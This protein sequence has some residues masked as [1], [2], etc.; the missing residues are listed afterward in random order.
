MNKRWILVTTTLLMIVTA[1][2]I[3]VSPV[4]AQSATRTLPDSVAPGETFEVRIE[5]TD[6]GMAGQVIETL[7]DGFSYVNSSLSPSQVTQEDQTVTFTLLGETSFTYNVTA[8]STPGTYTFSGI[9]KDFEKNEY[10]IGGDKEIKVIG[11][12]PTATRTLPT[13][14][15]PGETFEVRIEA[16]DYGMAGQ[17]IETLPDGFSYV[18]SSLSPSQVTQE[19]QTVTFT[20]LGETSFTYNVT[21][22]STPGTYTFSGILKDFEKNEYDIGGDSSIRVEVP[23][24]PTPTPTYRHA[25]GGVTVDSDGDGYSDSYEIRMGTDPHD[26]KSYPGAPTPKVTPTPSPSPSP[27]PTP[28]PILT[29]TPPLPGTPTPTPTLTPTPSP[30]PSP[31]PPGFEAIFAVA[32]LLAIAYLV[33]RRRK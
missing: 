5:A 14:V 31:T 26:P 15:A 25:P 29:P 8:S 9:L 28:T 1:S 4:A 18:N 6:Y 12:V 16:T 20:L 10:D 17:V 33:L 13:S 19:D 24:T 3:A 7:P 23:S 2:S 27:T 32:G 21:A 11:I 22:S 30:S